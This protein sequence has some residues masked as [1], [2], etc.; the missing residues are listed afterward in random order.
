[1]VL[2]LA[3]VSKRYGR[4]TALDRVS[5]A[6]APGAALGLLGP[7]GA[8]KTTTL[9]LLLG[10]TRASEGQVRLRGRVPSDPASRLG[11]AYLPERL[12]LPAR[13]TYGRCASNARGWRAPLVREIAGLERTGLAGRAGDRSAGSRRPR[14]ARRLRAGA[15][16]CRC[17]CSTSRP[18]GSIPSAC[19]TPATGS[20]PHAPAAPACS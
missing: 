19:A 17:C 20:S 9:R 14:A 15:L 7:N 4:R 10:F 8:G 5:L 1:M 12:A 11:V 18:P 13:M 6:L 3:A 2:E 16:S